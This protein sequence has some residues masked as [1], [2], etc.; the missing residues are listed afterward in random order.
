MLG[1]S[2]A[3]QKRKESISKQFSYPDPISFKAI[4]GYKPGQECGK[5]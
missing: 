3:K 4:T 1:F 5:N 2:E